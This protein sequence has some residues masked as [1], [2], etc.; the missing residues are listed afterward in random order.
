MSDHVH[1]TWHQHHVSR[2]EREA[3]NGH[4]GCVVWFTGLSG[5]GKSTVA[6]VVDH[7][8][9]Q[10]GLHSFLLDGDNIRHGLNASPELLAEQGESFAQRFGLGFSADDRRENIRRI[11]AVA[12]LFASAGL[13]TLTA[14][15]SPYR[16]DR[17]AARRQ[18]DSRGAAG[19]F[20]EVWVDAPLEVC[21]SRD[22]KGLYRKAR[23]GE[24]TG[25][26]GIDDP[27]EPP[28]HPQ[29]VLDSAT[30]APET[31][32]DQVLEYLRHAG[33]IFS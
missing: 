17:E 19:D 28:E 6:N 11:A 8:L 24:I 23:A 12:E 32:A 33:R 21:E 4:R 22:P 3:L 30:H 13:I 25:F 5:C 31:L 9:H 18:I 27:Y 15:V 1:V 10:L 14:F 16:R 26:T 20:I 2:Q 7:K 29:L